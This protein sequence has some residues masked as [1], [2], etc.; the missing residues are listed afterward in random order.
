MTSTKSAIFYLTQNTEVR[1]T[2]LKTSLYFLFRNFNA[3][4]KYPVIL[5]HEGDYD[6]KSQEDVLMSVRDSCRSLVSFQTLDKEDFEIPAHIDKDRVRK[7]VALRPVPY[8]RNEKYRMMC[9]WWTVLMHK[10]AKNYDYIMRLDDDSF[11]EEP[12]QKD[13]F[14]VMKDKGFVYASNI[15]H[16]DCGMCSYGMRDFFEKHVPSKKSLMDELFIASKIP[17]RA[18]QCHTFRSVMSINGDLKDP[19]PEEIVTWSPIIYYNNFFVTDMNFWRRDDVQAL[20]KDID[21]NGS[22]FYYRWGDA[23]LHTLIVSLMAGPDKIE[24]FKF[25]YSKRMQREAFKGDD[26]HLHCYMP[27]DYA[28]SSCM[29]E[30]V[31]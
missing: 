13:M 27:G 26:G 25:K 7:I 31:K 29:S 17:M 24:R 15:I 4:Y 3:K 28:Q 21:S 20:V 19:A 22:I 5:F 12:V 18:I 16:N 1:R 8:W 10:Y 11:I 23:P 9:R 6:L 2:Y 14:Q 30:Q